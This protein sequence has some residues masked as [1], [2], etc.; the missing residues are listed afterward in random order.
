MIQQR[1]STPKRIRTNDFSERALVTIVLSAYDEEPIFGRNCFTRMSESFGFRHPY[2]PRLRWAV[3]GTCRASDSHG[4][5][6]GVEP[7]IVEFGEFGGELAA[8][9]L[10]GEGLAT[11]GT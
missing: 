2:L 7:G 4:S 6:D 9:G 5:G 10:N 1:S 8:R 3:R 11:D